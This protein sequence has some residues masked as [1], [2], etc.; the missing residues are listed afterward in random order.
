MEVFKNKKIY[1]IAGVL[2][3]A[4]IPFVLF[5]F[6]KVQKPQNNPNATN[7]LT[8]SPASL[9]NLSIISITPRDNSTSPNYYQQVQVTFSRSVTGM[10]KSQIQIQISPPIH[11]SQIWDNS[12]TLLT[13][14]PTTAL[15]PSQKYTITVTYG[16]SDINTSFT[17]L[18]TD[19]A[20][21]LQGQ[22]DKNFNQ[23]LQNT[24]Q[25]YPWFSQLP[26]QT[27]NYFV[28]FDLNKKQFIARIYNGPSLT[29]TQLTATKNEIQSKLSSL[30]V[31]LNNF[32]VDWQLVP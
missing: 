11:A 22:A 25:Q 29:Q 24:A 28:Y 12:N 2:L 15:S 10:E 16:N 6:Q 27:D 8:P 19:Q 14:T 5:L 20:T 23:Q 9:S 3:L 4:L 26:L 1:Y 30:G 18:S 32:T 7:A 21:Q 17:T 13:A 31:N